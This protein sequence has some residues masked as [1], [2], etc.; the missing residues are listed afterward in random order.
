[1]ELTYTE[2][3]SLTASAVFFYVAEEG[4][5]LSV[6]LTAHRP[7]TELSAYGNPFQKREIPDDQEEDP[8][9]GIRMNGDDDDENGTDDKYDTSVNGEND[10][11]EVT[12]NVGPARAPSG[13]EY[14]LKRNNDNI[15]VWEDQT[16]GTEI[17][18]W[19]TDEKVVTFSSETKT[20][21]V[22]CVDAG[23]C[24]LELIARATA[25]SSTV[26]SD[27]LFFD[28]FSSVVI[29]LGG[30]GQNP[31]DPADPNAG[32]FNAAIDLYE[33]GYD[34]HMYD[35]DEVAAGGHGAPY[36]EVIESFFARG[37]IYVAVYGYSRGGGATHDLS[38][39]LHNSG[40]D[41]EFTGYCDA[42]ESGI[43]AHDAETRRPPGSGLHVN[44]YQRHEG[45]VLDLLGDATVGIQPGDIQVN[46]TAAGWTD[47]AG[48]LLTHFTLD[49]D[50]R[51][52][53]SIRNQIK[54]AIPQ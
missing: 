14:V 23:R 8:G 29:A 28:S 31:T 47:A 39:A 50:D 36:E 33:E 52:L 37:V 20:V 54:S 12:L 4:S 24:D 44:Y 45:G 2:T 38:D 49:D 42:I 21:W 13:I 43:I 1:M 11:I 26:C 27:K 17:L 32:M 30:F 9:V 34:V 10:L 18:G 16:K 35:E 48:N 15:L 53:D 46:A 19:F 40:I 22:E 7:T 51:V 41:P 6:G 25:D 3:V 5:I